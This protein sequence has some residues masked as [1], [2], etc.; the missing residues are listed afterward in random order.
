MC[1]NH[2][3][4]LHPCFDLQSN[5]VVAQRQ[6]RLQ[7]C[8]RLVLR[9]VKDGRSSGHGV[10]C[11]RWRHWGRP[12]SR[13]AN[14]MN[15]YDMAPSLGRKESSD[16]ESWCSAACCFNVKLTRGNQLFTS[17]VLGTRQGS[18]LTI[19]GKYTKH[20]NVQGIQRYS[21]WEV[22]Q[23]ML[24]CWLDASPEA[25]RPNVTLKQP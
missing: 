23:W 24:Y 7:S 9:Q 16:C 17:T 25:T 5:I 3:C 14:D 2:N 10:R 11:D 15:D 13:L 6:I 8:Q 22:A 19:A 18:Q 20:Q 4:S 21:N 1:W 12:C